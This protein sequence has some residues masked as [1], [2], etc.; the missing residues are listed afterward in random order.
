[1]I[2]FLVRCHLPIPA[3]GRLDLPKTRLRYRNGFIRCWHDRAKDRITCVLEDRDGMSMAM[4]THA[5]ARAEALLM[6]QVVSAKLQAHTKYEIGDETG[7][8]SQVRV[9]AG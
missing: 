7:D 5:E 4:R 9:A 1:M 8:R 2:G 6:G 3:L